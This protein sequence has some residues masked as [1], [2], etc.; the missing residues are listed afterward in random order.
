VHTDL[1]DDA[2]SRITQLCEEGDDLT[3]RDMFD[4][5]IKKYEQ[6]WNLLPHPK[7]DW[8]AATW[9]LTAIGDAL[10]FAGKFEQSR[11]VFLHAMSCPDAIGNPFLHLRLGQVYFELNDVS[12]SLDELMRAYMGGGLEIFQHQDPKYIQLLEATLERETKQRQ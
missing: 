5:A 12:K 9:I 2:Y 8:D 10:F 6:A 7:E 3:N 4:A 11:E 1:D